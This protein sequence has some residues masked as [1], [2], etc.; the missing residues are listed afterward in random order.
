M[1]VMTVVGT[2]PELIKLSRVIA[3]L[4][5]AAHHVLVHT[6][7]NYDH[8][9][10]QIFFDDLGLRL[11]DHRLEVAG[12]S[13]AGTIGNVITRTDE[14]FAREKPDA[15]LVLGDTNSC[16]C[17]IP[18]KRRRI[19]IFHMEAGNRCFDERVPEETN[20]RIVDHV[21]DVNLPYTEHARRYL[22]AEGLRGET[23]IKTGSP[24]K[25][26]LTHYSARIASSD[27]L[28]RLELKKDGYLIVSAHR[29]EN[30]DSEENFANLLDALRAVAEKFKRPVIVSTHPR[31][32]KKL[33]GTAGTPFKSDVRFLKPLGFTD[34]VRMQQDSFCVLS[35]SGTITEESSILGFPA[36]M[37]RQ[38]HERPEGMEVGTLV[39]SGLEPERVVESV[40]LVTSRGG[41][42]GYRAAI[43]PDYDVADLSHRIV[44]IIFSYTD[45]INRTVWRT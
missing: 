5:E 18:A 33:E 7:Q 32:R 20:R 19:P 26:V 22:L 15:L 10:N 12:S 43:A 25:E 21:S 29:E 17:V 27:V 14:I 39:M 9:L 40:A 1:K 42:A 31:T 30:I 44:T 34:Y 35:D 24:M 45:Y 2:R 37:L 38:A 8:E 11:P 36:V 41:A 23:V 4:D 13:V 3:A 28:R 16:L 6:Q